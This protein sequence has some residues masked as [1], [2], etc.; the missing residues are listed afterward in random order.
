[1]DFSYSEQSLALQAQLRAFYEE[2]IVHRWREWQT[3]VKRDNVLEPDFVAGLRELARSQG[4]WNLALP[5][6]ENDDPGGG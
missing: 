1:M 2:H 6:L 3:L 4:L 5:D